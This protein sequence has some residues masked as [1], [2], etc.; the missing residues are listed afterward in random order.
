[1]KRT[2]II[3]SGTIT[4]LVIAFFTYDLLK[5]MVSPCETI[6]QQTA[7]QLGTKL[8]LIETEQEAFIGKE[9]I[10]DLTE[11]AQVT[12]LNLKTCCLVLRAGNVDSNQFLQCKD[13]TKKYE[14]KVERVIAQT[15]QAEAAKR[16]GNTK[17][18]NEKVQQIHLSVDEAMRISE[19]FQNQVGVISKDR[20]PK[21]VQG[22]P[23]QAETQPRPV[24]AP[25]S[26]SALKLTAILA[27]GSE[28]LTRNLTY[29]VYE[30]K[31]DPE[32]KRKYVAHSYDAAPLF[33]LPAGRY[34][35]TVE[36]RGANAS[37]DVEVAAGQAHEIKLEIKIP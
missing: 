20:Q 19:A 28:P 1:M 27:E 14:E 24:R 2:L 7:V 29:N 6:F 32:G 11:A 18:F 25:A 16:E 22:E 9:K 35:V 17:V 3:L 34:Y 10:Q 4:I 36:Y 37:R 30:A 23:V 13:T 26:E 31:K 33:R 21:S 12:A 15:E 5:G 8:K